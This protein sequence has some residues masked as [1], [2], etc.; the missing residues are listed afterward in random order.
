MVFKHNFVHGDLH[1]GPFSSDRIL[2]HSGTALAG[3][4]LVTH[5]PKKGYS[6]IFLDCGI[7]TKVTTQPTSFVLLTASS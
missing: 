5:D 1:P 7:V 2:P 4:I 3:N 6:L